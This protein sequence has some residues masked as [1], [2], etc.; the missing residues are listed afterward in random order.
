MP[1][2]LIN[3]HVHAHGG[4]CDSMLFFA[5]RSSE[6]RWE[7]WDGRDDERGLAQIVTLEYLIHSYFIL[8]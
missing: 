2:I 7:G 6:E 4:F 8:E 1:L 3:I 5:M